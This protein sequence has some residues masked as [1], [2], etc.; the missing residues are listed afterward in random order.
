MP[1]T[2]ASAVTW[3]KGQQR[4]ETRLNFGLNLLREVK[5]LSKKILDLWSASKEN[6]IVGAGGSRRAKKMK[7]GDMD[8]GKLANREEQLPM[9]QQGLQRQSGN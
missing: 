8:V 9:Q 7:Q 4:R 1:G 5:V 6:S 2:R 3:E